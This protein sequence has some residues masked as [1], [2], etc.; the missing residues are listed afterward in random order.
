MNIKQFF[1]WGLAA[2]LVVQVA[3]TAAAELAATTAAS[4]S[5]F[6][7]YK[8]PLRGAPASRVGGG[9]RGADSGGAPRIAVLAPDHTGLTTQ[10]QPD[11]YWYLSKPVATK[12]E[13]T[14]IN[15]QA[16]QPLVEKKLDTPTRAGIQRLR[17]KD[18]GI[19]LKPGIEY[20]WFVGMVTDPQQRSN[21]VI[22]SGTI[23][24]SET[25][26]TLTQKL[27][28]AD[29][30]A[31]PFIYAEEGYWYDAIATISDLIAANPGDAVLRQQRAALLEQA[32]LDEAARFDLAKP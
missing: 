18:L 14:V 19:Q 27:A 8:P 12:L 29:K 16:V 22:A 21:D 3:A 30:R 1:G 32:G 4:S 11:L 10:T 17:L 28:Q 6:P 2:L 24:R 20:R 5:P 31:V 7:A 25:P 23:M 15:D 13:I 26:S 9:S